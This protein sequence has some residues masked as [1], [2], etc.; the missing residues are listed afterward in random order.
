MKWGTIA[1]QPCLCLVGD[2]CR[3][4]ARGHRGIAPDLLGFGRSPKPRSAAYDVDCHVDAR[5][6]HARPTRSS[7]ASL[8]R[9]YGTGLDLLDEREDVPNSLRWDEPFAD[10]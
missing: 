3:R 6:A 2:V 8:G 4:A 5:M 1:L 10:E 7:R 9:H